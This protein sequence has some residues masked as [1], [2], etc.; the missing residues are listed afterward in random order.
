L[1]D[2]DTALAQALLLFWEHGYESTSLSLLKD[3]MGGITAPSFYAA[4]KSKEGLFSEV[5]DLY[6]ATHGTVTDPLWDGSLGPRRAIERTLRGSARMQTERGHPKGCLLVLAASTCSS[7]NAH[8][9]KLLAAQ[10]ARTREGFQRRVRE[11]V[12]A[13]ELP[14]NTDVSGYAATLHG[15]LWG[16]STQARDDVP[17]AALDT[18]IDYLMLTWSN[19][20]AV[21]RSL[22]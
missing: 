5:V 4:F 16:L 6:M 13:G 1:F 22:P 8:V 12:D 9:Q 15:C 14:A 20:P 7:D 11:G 21:A 17:I 2:R 10:R 18:S 19:P 3:G